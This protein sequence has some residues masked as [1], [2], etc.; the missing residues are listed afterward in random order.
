MGPALADARARTSA[1]EMMLRGQSQLAVW[2]YEPAQEFVHALMK[3]TFLLSL[4]RTAPQRSWRG[5]RPNPR[6]AH[7]RIR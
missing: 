4:P 7:D 2:I 3:G 1:N 6:R 5:R